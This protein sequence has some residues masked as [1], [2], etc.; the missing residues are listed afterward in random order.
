MRLQTD[1]HIDHY[2]NG[3]QNGGPRFVASP[4]TSSQAVFSLKCD[5]QVRLVF[6]SWKSMTVLHHLYV[7]NCSRLF[8]V[9]AVLL[10][11]R[12]R[13]RAGD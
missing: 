10:D 1:T 9:G 8:R 3:K 12:N 4:K 2:R 6:D 5:F 7:K 13:H 11:I